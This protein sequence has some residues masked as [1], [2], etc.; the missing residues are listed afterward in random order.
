MVGAAAIA[1]YSGLVAEFVSHMFHCIP[2]LPYQRRKSSGLSRPCVS[3]GLSRVRTYSPGI[4]ILEG[5]YAASFLFERRNLSECR[6]AVILGIG[7]E[8]A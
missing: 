5:S 1:K 8:T 2:T 4:G 3:V 7:L 6:G